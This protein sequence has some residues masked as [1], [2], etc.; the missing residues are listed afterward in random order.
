MIKQPVGNMALLNDELKDGPEI[1]ENTDTEWFPE[2]ERRHS[3]SDQGSN[4]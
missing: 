2:E 1:Y 3:Q 4:Q